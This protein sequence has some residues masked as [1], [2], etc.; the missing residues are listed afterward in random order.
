MSEDGVCI[1]EIL[2]FKFLNK[3]FTSNQNLILLLIS[4]RNR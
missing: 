2:Q 1:T 4:L 3:K